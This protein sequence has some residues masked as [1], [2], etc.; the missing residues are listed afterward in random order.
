MS[1]RMWLGIS[2]SETLLIPS[3]RSFSETPVAIT[4]E[5][6]TSSG[7]LVK[8][9]IT[10]K[11]DFTLNYGR[12]TNEVK[13]QLETIYALDTTLNF[14]VERKDSTIDD[15]AVLMRPVESS[16][17]NAHGPWLHSVFVTLE[18]V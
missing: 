15:Y 3:G 4:R 12:T 14:Q 16:R 7:K 5:G 10:T 8:D 13:E 6:R 18:E 2:G 9:L 11:N 17:I 1:S